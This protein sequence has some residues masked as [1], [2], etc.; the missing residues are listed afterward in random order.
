M[1]SGVN[2]RR[3][4]WKCHR[5]RIWARDCHPGLI[6]TDILS[7]CWRSFLAC[8]LKDY[9]IIKIISAYKCLTF[10]IGGDKKW[11]ISNISSTNWQK[12][13]QINFPFLQTHKIS[14]E[15]RKYSYHHHFHEFSSIWPAGSCNFG[16]E[17]IFLI[18][19]IWEIR[20]RRPFVYSLTHIFGNFLNSEQ[21][22]S[23][24]I[25]FVRF[26]QFHFL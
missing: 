17:S 26:V 3:H 2:S 15:N 8:T 9:N 18:S 19:P 23:I 13:F 10:L 16:W 20:V 1:Y 4:C 22:I 5:I 21:H 11:K 12:L 14:L 7:Y 6:P 24:W 25:E